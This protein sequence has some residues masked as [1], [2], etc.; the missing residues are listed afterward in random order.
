MFN[1][2]EET[3]KLCIDLYAMYKRNGLVYEKGEMLV[4][5][6]IYPFVRNQAKLN[7]RN[8]FSEIGIYIPIQINLKH[9]PKY[10][11]KW[12][13]WAENE[14]ERFY[15]DFDND[16][17]LFSKMDIYGYFRGGEQ[18]YWYEIIFT[19]QYDGPEE[20]NRVFIRLV[21][22]KNGHEG[23]IL[24]SKDS[25]TF[26]FFNDFH[27]E[28]NMN[29]FMIDHS[30]NRKYRCNIQTN[31]QFV[32]KIIASDLS[33]N[34]VHFDYSYTFEIGKITNWLNWFLEHQH[35]FSR[36]TTPIDLDNGIWDERQLKDFK[37]RIS[38]I[39][40]LIHTESWKSE[41]EEDIFMICTIHDHQIKPFPL[42][43]AI[44]AEFGTYGERGC[45]YIAQDLESLENLIPKGLSAN[46]YEPLNKWAHWNHEQIHS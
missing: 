45:I 17:E 15:L 5:P 9:F 34:V 20:N 11:Q 27:R 39:K 33:D 14:L 4:M 6:D 38:K 24:I 16:F 26:P 22:D 13:T 2:E 42:L 30:G 7:A 35:K 28:F 36:R 19:L 31:D 40:H 25:S 29:K 10:K 12:D 18:Q 43:V 23:K 21:Y 8:S 3:I 44:C 32:K 1:G 46:F 41:I 37:I